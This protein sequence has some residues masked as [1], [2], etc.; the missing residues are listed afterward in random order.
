MNFSPVA[1][2]VFAG[3]IVALIPALCSV[4]AADDSARFQLHGEAVQGG[5]LLG[6]A[7]P[8]AK[9]FFNGT[10][11][12][13]S[14]AGDFVFGF[15]RDAPRQ[16]VLRI[17]LPSNEEKDAHSRV[18]EVRAR[19]Y[20]E[21]RIEQLD[22]R[23]VTPKPEDLE[24]IRRERRRIVAARTRDDPRTDFLD[25][26][27]WPVR[28][29]ITGVYGSRRILNGQ[30]RSPH[31]GIDIACR[32]GAPVKAPASGIV[33]FVHDDMFFS[34]ATLVL[35]HGHGVSSTFLHL[36]KILVE[37]GERIVRGHI[38]GLVGASGRATGAHLDWR[39]NWFGTRLDP[40]LLA[41][42]MP[43]PPSTACVLPT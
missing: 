38:I 24:R 6:R 17:I 39:A 15:G 19:E 36:Q 12:R 1:V 34:G 31:F 5:V 2:P 35:D 21:Q 40:A 29:I 43:A 7:A 9:V 11:I 37:E 30:P 28:G 42:E 27:E 3:T 13:V 14:P 22:P 33:T 4:V 10:R 16:A 41:G 23:K 18:I 32:E 8:G 25:G 26:F 20:A